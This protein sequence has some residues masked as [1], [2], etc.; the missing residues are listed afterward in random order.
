[1]RSEQNLMEL[2]ATG[3]GQDGVRW[4]SQ[5]LGK[6]GYLAN[7]LASNGLP[8]DQPA[9]RSAE[10]PARRL[11]KHQAELDGSWGKTSRCSTS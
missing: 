3:R 7:G 2:R 4:G 5:L 9:A 10:D 1:M 11:R 8:P 6:F